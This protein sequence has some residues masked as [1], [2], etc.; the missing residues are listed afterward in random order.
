MAY[1]KCDD[2]TIPIFD[3]S[4]YSNWKKRILKF[5]QFK[6]CKQVTERE[7]LLTDKIEEWEEMDTKATNYIYS[8]ITNKQLE[9]ICNLD[10]AY[11]I[12]K[13]FDEMYL[14]KSTALQIVCR[15]NLEAIKLKNYSEITTFFDEFEKAINELKAAGAMIPKQEKLNYMLK[16]LPRTYSHI[17]DLIDV[18]PEKYRTVEYLKSKIKLKSVEEK[19]VEKSEEMPAKSNVFTAVGTSSAGSKQPI[20]CYNCGK[21]GHMRKDC[22]HRNINSGSRGRGQN[23][24]G[25][26]RFQN[27]RGHYQTNKASCHGTHEGNCFSAE[28][29]GDMNTKNQSAKDKIVW[30]LDNGCTNHI[31]NNDIYFEKCVT[32]KEPMSVKVGNGR[33]LQATK[34][35]NIKTLFEVFHKKS[36]VTLTNVF[37]VKNM[38]ENLISYSKVM[39]N[40]NN[41]RVVFIGNITKVYNKYNEIIAV[42][43]REKNLLKIKNYVKKQDN[44]VCVNLTTGLGEQGLTQKEKWH[45]TLGHINFNYLKN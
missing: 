33:V 12:I 11:K 3:G 7:I 34:I 14:E 27:Y 30:I 39:D 26:G 45:R 17:G 13:K 22:R 9:Y 23:S 2:I 40:N 38:K 43:T 6:K 16:A 32:L 35:G 21:S 31:V 10:S 25:H 29:N 44:K 1:V 42:A 19:N 4:D 41:N 20:T 8:A 37:Y 36:E 24:R 15:N 28:V 18:L 5:L